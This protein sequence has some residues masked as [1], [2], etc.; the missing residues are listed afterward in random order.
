ME[1]ESKLY[2][3]DLNS[4][5]QHLSLLKKEF[6]NIISNP[7][8]NNN[9]I[10]I[11][12][13]NNL[14]IQI[15][16]VAKEIQKFEEINISETNN[17]KVKNINFSQYKINNPEAPI[18]NNI[19]TLKSSKKNLNKEILN[20]NNEIIQNKDMNKIIVFNCL[21]TFDMDDYII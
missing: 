11:S 9:N 12:Y 5:K 1:Y 15:K 7:E 6:F 19:M 4:L 16:E 20:N 10:T 21:K 3:I 2:K 17:T 14:L 8:T 18:N 13:K